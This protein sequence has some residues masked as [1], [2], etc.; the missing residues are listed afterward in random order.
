MWL[1]NRLSPIQTTQLA[2]GLTT[3]SRPPRKQ[4]PNLRQQMKSC[5]RCRPSP[6]RSILLP[7]YSPHLL[8]Q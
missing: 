2:T 8:V 4:K 3:I 6:F 7:A 5:P 1:L